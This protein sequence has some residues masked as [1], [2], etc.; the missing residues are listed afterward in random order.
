MRSSLLLLLAAVFAMNATAQKNFTASIDSFMTAEVQSRHFNGNVLVAKA[1]KIIY[2]KSFGYSNYDTKEPLDDN[3]LFELASVSKQFTAVAILELKEQGK[4]SLSDTLRKFFPELPY[5]NVTIKHMLTHTSGLPDYMD[6]MA[7]KWDHKRIA[8]NKDVIEFLATEKIP[9]DFKPG[10]KCVYSNTAYEMLASIVEKVSGEPF[11]VYMMEHVFK[12]AGLQHTRIYNTRRS[13]EVLGNY[14][15]GY[16]WSDSLKRY[17]LPD[18]IASQDFVFYLDGI[19]GDGVV[20]STTGDLLQ[21]DRALKSHRL[22]SAGTQKEMFTPH[23]TFDTAKKFYYGYGE[24]LGHNE[25]GPYIT[26]SGGWPGYHTNLTRYTDQDLTVIVL[27]NNQGE[28]D[29]L[30][31]GLSHIVLD[32]PGER[33]GGT[34]DKQ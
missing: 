18:S 9:M 32:R 12:P 23:S 14:A 1:G 13:G 17:V 3:S 26:H 4:L 5:S 10:E 20:N 21:W 15:Y 28:V 11:E 33:K 19:V 2:Q 16:I 31:R 27:S 22:L 6:A 34:G 8:F 30:S 7:P 25:I 29:K 24:F